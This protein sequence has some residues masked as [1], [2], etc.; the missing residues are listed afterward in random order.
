MNIETGK[1][2]PGA[3]RCPAISTQDI[4]AADKIKAPGW[5]ASEDYAYMGSE[6]ISKDRYIDPAFAKR[7]MESMWTRTWQFACREE[8]IPEA[9]DYYVYDL[10]HYSFIVTRVSE[11]EIKA[12]F[13][14]CLHRGTKLR[15]SGTSG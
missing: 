12:Y 13:N 8:H 14:A 1:L 6:S 7:E 10:G 3:A 11:T 5:V 4:I 15:P 9:G 2:I